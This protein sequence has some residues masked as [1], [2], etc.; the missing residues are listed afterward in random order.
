MTACFPPHHRNGVKR[1]SQ[2]DLEGYFGAINLL[3][4]RLT[5]QRPYDKHWSSHFT[6]V[7]LRYD[8]LSGTGGELLSL[9]RTFMCARIGLD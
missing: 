6:Y 8:L 2:G 9:G 5:T 7:Q 3:G 4:P 1:Q